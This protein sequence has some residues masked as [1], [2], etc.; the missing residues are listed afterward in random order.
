MQSKQTEEKGTRTSGERR[1][2]NEEKKK[3]EKTVWVRAFI[4]LIYLFMVPFHFDFHFSACIRSIGS[5]LGSGKRTD[6]AP[7]LGSF[8][9]VSSRDLVTSVVCR[10]RFSSY[11]YS[12]RFSR[13][14]KNDLKEEGAGGEG[15][16]KK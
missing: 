16:E 3:S 7:S 9:F 13:S 2:T 8:R 14:I 1:R 6:F 15:R 11:E 10:R 12:L 5:A 4:A